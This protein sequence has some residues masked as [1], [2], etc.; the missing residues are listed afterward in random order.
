M[1]SPRSEQVGSSQDGKV[2][3]DAMSNADS[4][5]TMIVHETRSVKM[6]PRK[7]DPIKV[8]EYEN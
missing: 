2:S 8:K 4:E 7:K 5:M 3:S 6:L 1:D